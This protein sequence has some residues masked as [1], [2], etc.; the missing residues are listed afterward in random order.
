M[1]LA[2][3]YPVHDAA[4]FL[5]AFI[6]AVAASKDWALD[7]I[8]FDYGFQF[9]YVKYVGRRFQGKGLKASAFYRLNDPT[10]LHATIRADEWPT[11]VHG[12]KSAMRL[13]KPL[14][15]AAHEASRPKLKIVRPPL[16]RT[17]ARPKGRRS[18]RQRVSRLGLV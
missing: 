3:C 5:D 6:G 17:P 1:L 8:K 15:E 2:S 11:H 14:L 10:T 7:C 18:L 16:A 13:V 4:A 9:V 12:D